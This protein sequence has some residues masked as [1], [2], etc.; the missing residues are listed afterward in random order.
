M[1]ARV[2][3]AALLLLLASCDDGGNPV[4]SDGA[5]GGGTDSESSGGP[6]GESG[7]TSTQPES[8]SSTDDASSGSAPSTGG[9]T[10]DGP[11]EAVVVLNGSFEVEGLEPGCFNN[12][13]NEEFTKTV[14]DVFAFGD[15]AQADL[16]ADCYG[17]TSDGLF[18]VGLG[19]NGDRSDAIALALSGPL[20]G[21]YILRF[22]A[23]HG[24]TGGPASTDV[25]VG[26]S[27]TPD[28]FGTEVGLTGQLSDDPQPHTFEVTGTG[29]LYI[30]L[31]V[32]PDGDLGWAMLDAVTLEPA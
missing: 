15:Y 24:A 8:T 26:L 7:S 6:P 14:P 13:S 21:D 22:I 3:F 1:H 2:P 11:A 20:E 30:T 5:S 17:D 27:D 28:Q 19:A 9:S 18:H 31:R 10:T 32:V 23:D 29:Q 12:L 16:Y 25:A 4:G